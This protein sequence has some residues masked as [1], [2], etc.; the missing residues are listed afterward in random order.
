MLFQGLR[1]RNL[2]R[3][4][5]AQR[6][7]LNRAEQRQK[8][9]DNSKITGDKKMKTIK[10]MMTAVTLMM[11]LMVGTSFGG[12]FVTSLQ[13]PQ[14]CTAETNITKSGVVILS[15][16]VG[17]FVT[18]LTGVFVTNSRENVDCGVIVIN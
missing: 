17:V 13:E 12:V 3:R 7:L 1:K 16:I 10:K 18:S 4:Y 15:D 5:L 2:S 11:V 9:K 14:P 8:L 6:L